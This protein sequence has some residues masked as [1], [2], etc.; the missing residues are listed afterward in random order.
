MTRLDR[1]IFFSNEM[2]QDENEHLCKI[3]RSG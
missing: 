2:K 3:M 1:T